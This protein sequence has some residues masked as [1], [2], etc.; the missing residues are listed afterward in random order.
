M[1]ERE[2]TRPAMVAAAEAVFLAKGIHAA[3]MEDVAGAAGVTRRTLYRHFP[4]KEELAYEAAC[5]VLEG[6]NRRLARIGAGLSGNGA[7]RLRAYLGGAAR[8]L[9]AHLDVARFT[10][11]FDH[12]FK[13]G[14][15]YSP[16]SDLAARYAA[17]SGASDAILVG[18]LEDGVEDGS[19]DPAMDVRL[20]AFAISNILWGY[21]QRL[22]SRRRQ[23]R[24]EYG[25]DP[26]RLVFH[27]IDLYVK[28]LERR[29]T[30]R[31]APQGPK[32]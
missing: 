8:K 21:G 9:A 4:G 1:A 25:L 15:G 6:W 3:S 20:T 24:K 30:D 16:P 27:Q 17:A 18:I 32:R 31:H 5:A 13:D 19:L 10:G 12:Y 28:A 29:A 22:A 14:S 2:G 11:E 23:L 26:M 7:E